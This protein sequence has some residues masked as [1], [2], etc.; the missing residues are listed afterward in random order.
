VEW[1]HGATS[2]LAV[3]DKNGSGARIDQLC[4]PTDVIVDNEG[5]YLIIA[6]SNNR[7]VV[8]RPRRNG[9]RGEIII[10]DISCY[11]LTLD[12]DGY[13]YVSDCDRHEVKR[14]RIED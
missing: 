10:S 12:N 8:R 1:K 3:A 14:W 11:G 9:T 5:E 7:R 4:G 13:L 2:G 6:E